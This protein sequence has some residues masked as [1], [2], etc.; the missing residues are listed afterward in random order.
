MIKIADKYKIGPDQDVPEVCILEHGINFG[1]ASPYDEYCWDPNK[2]YQK[3][4][5]GALL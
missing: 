2:A 5:I 4:K 3:L 1:Y